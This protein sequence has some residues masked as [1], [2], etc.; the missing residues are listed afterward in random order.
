M[1]EIIFRTKRDIN[2]NTYYLII[3]LE[4]KKAQKGYNFGWGRYNEAIETTK[5]GIRDI[6]QKFLNAGFKIDYV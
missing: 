2:G 5:K 4:T 6:E 1:N 3:E